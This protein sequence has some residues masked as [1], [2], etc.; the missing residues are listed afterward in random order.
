MSA[1]VFRYDQIDSDVERRLDNLL[2]EMAL[3]EKVGQL[4]Q[5]TATAMPDF[6]EIAKKQKE[7]AAAGVPFRFEAQPRPGL[8]ERVRAGQIGSIFG[9]ADAGLINRM[10]RA[11]VQG[12]RLGIPLL[13][14]ND[15]I[16]GFRTVFPIPLA[17]SCTWDPELLQQ[18]ARVAAE[19]ASACGT[20][21]IFAPMLDI[22]RDPRWGRI[23]EGAGEDPFLGMAMARA[24]VLGFQSAGLASGRRVAA[25]PK[26]YIA[27]GAAEAGRDYNT[28]DISERS[29]RDVYLPP[30]KAAF[31]AGAGSVMSSFNE[32]SGVPATI[33]SFILRTILRDELDW[34]G[35]V[36]S[37]YDAIREVTEH[38]AAADLKDAAR[39]S[40]LAGLDMDMVSEAY[41]AHLVALVDEGSLTEELVTEAARRVLR[42]KMRLGLF[43][44]PYVDEELA[45]N[46]ILREDFRAVALETARESMVLLKNKD[47]LLPLTPGQH[48]L[49][50]IGPLADAAREMLGTWA[51]FGQPEDVDTVLESIQAAQAGGVLV[52]A[53]GCPIA[54]AEPDGIAAALQAASM[55][56]VIILVLGEGAGMSGEA[57]SRAHL[58]L[59]GRQQELVDA[60]A[61]T[62]KPMVCVLMSGRP[63][64]VPRLAG[65]VD[66]LLAAWHGGI[67]AGRAVADI[68]F[69]A[70]SPSGK[71]T[72]A[73]PRSEGQIPLYYGHKNT[74][75][76]MQ[77]V[78]TTQFLEPYKSGYIDEANEP[79]FPFG[80]GQSYTRFE[81]SELSVET[82]VVSVDGTL[83]A[84][85][86]L[87]NAGAVAG[88]E[89]V[90]LYVRDLVG[91]L[92]RP[93]RELKGFQRVTL[94][95]GMECRVS[96]EVPAAEL[97]FH[98][99]DMQYTVEPGAFK[100]WIGPYSASGLEGDFTLA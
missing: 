37:D 31:E 96:F 90:Q 10:Q 1:E 3:E 30:F 68:L 91:S 70:V 65:Q 36:V 74:G 69:G 19:E 66:A 59:P 44:K 63:L 16:H 61:A 35:M 2:A 73:W 45:P 7:A 98:G 84:S 95:P 89:V 100:L 6:E 25:C 9:C 64:V 94:Q 50:V 93:V 67:R 79:L 18:A 77:G 47:G 46:L 34:A 20:D 8:E 14:G 83:R 21:W 17:E 88:T 97:G 12:S 58:G 15:V 49:A 78:G 13:V 5:L 26:H 48:R 60:L 39:K 54:S 52:H 80:Y 27:Y 56:D 62:G 11:A 41:A 99:L 29:L 85:V 57:H 75:R 24:R 53:P 87:K 55:A 92:T 76:P 40:L 22:S 72:A 81:Y 4:V 28:V 33:N 51:I 32:L 23:A 82:P 42:L 86:L 43:E 71:L 38:G